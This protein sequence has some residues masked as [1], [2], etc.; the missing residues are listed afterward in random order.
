M[1][2]SENSETSVVCYEQKNLKHT[3]EVNG[4]KLEIKVIDTRKWYE[5]IGITMGES[6]I[7]VYLPETEYKN[8][9]IETT[10]SEISSVLMQDLADEKK[11]VIATNRFKPEN[12]LVGQNSHHH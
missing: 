1:K 10:Y 7:I 2:K 4:E 12:I 6:D 5:Y 3:V 11:I 8:L 9:L